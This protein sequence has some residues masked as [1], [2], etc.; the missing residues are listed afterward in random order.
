MR[1]TE[2]REISKA[3][4]ENVACFSTFMA[5][6]EIRQ[7]AKDG[8]YHVWLKGKIMSEVQKELEEK[9]YKILTDERRP[10]QTQIQW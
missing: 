10:G 9:G 7:A 5:L 4:G 1:A 3:A 2:A 8:N 6:I